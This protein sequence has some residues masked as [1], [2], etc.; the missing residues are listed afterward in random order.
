M[1][2]LIIFLILFCS[3]ISSVFGEDPDSLNSFFPNTVRNYWVYKFKDPAAPQSYF[4]N[5]TVRIIKDTTILNSQY[6]VHERIWLPDSSAGSKKYQYFRMDSTG[7]VYTLDSD[8]ESEMLYLKFDV[9]I[10]DTFSVHWLSLPGVF[11]VHSIFYTDELKNIQFYHTWGDSVSDSYHIMTFRDSIGYMGGLYGFG[12][13]E[14]IQGYYIN[15]KLVG[16]TLVY[17]SLRDVDQYD[18]LQFHLHGNYP[19]PFNPST[20]IKYSLPTSGDVEL[21][22][23][24]IKGQ[25]V[26]R[27]TYSNQTTGL[28]HIEFEGSELS[29]GI[30]FYQIRFNGVNKTRKFILLK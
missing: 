12:F 7:I 5:F 17:T 6:S 10:G 9:S 20:T 22:I 29:S 25:Q 23:F 11:R 4:I 18:N 27:N 3:Y 30:Y 14:D 24:N 28:N 26:F 19:N 1:K 15:G 13:Q 8:Q 2:K 16:D 21:F